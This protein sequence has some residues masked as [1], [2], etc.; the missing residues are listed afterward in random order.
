MY[1]ENEKHRSRQRSN[2]EFFRRMNADDLRLGLTGSDIPTFSRTDIPRKDVSPRTSCDGTS[3]SPAQIQSDGYASCK[4]PSLAMVYAPMQ[5]W[6]ELLSPLD[7]LHQG[8]I[9][10]ELIK[11]L[12]VSPFGSDH[13]TEG[14]CCK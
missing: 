13:H 6:Q 12:E 2:D 7:G 1:F 14:G 9:F 11:P 3:T 10:K 5:A 8:S 4:M